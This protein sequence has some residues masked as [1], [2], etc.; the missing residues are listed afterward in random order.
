MSVWG[1]YSFYS[2][3]KYNYRK[4]EQNAFLQSC[5]SFHFIVISEPCKWSKPT[6]NLSSR[7]ESRPSLLRHKSESVPFCSPLGINI[8]FISSRFWSWLYQ[9]DLEWCGLMQTNIERSGQKNEE[10]EAV[11]LDE[12]ASWWLTDLTWQF[13]IFAGKNSRDTKLLF[14]KVKVEKSWF[15]P[16]MTPIMLGIRR[17]AETY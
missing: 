16:T 1:M 9:R 3:F 8:P 15:V 17:V 12:R 6:K 5:K 2:L 11:N 7:I 13:K 10:G 14:T 4:I